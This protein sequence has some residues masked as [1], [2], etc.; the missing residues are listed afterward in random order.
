M[1]VFAING[2][3]M[4]GKD[5]FTLRVAQAC[6]PKIA[7]TISTIDPVKEY[8]KSIGWN[9]DK[10]DPVH[11]KILNTIKKMWILEHIRIAD[12]RNPYDWVCKQCKW[13]EDAKALAVFVMVREFEEMMKIV[14]IGKKDF[15]GGATIRVVRDGLEVPPVELEFIQSHPEDYMYDYTIVNPTTDNKELPNLMDA[16]MVFSNLLKYGNLE[17][18]SPLIWNPDWKLFHQPKIRKQIY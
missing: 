9:G 11:R 2:N 16:A 10:F 15:N 1:Q 17:D 12:C 13:Y 6:D 14:E 8:Y 5:S 18:G 7:V 4:A 3:A